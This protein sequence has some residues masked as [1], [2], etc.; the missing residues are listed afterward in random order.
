M[1]LQGEPEP[2]PVIGLAHGLEALRETFSIAMLTAGAYLRAA[3]Y[4]IP[5]RVGPF[6]V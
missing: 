6:D 4:G 3:G 1:R 2:I 5:R